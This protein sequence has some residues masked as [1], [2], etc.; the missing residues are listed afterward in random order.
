[1]DT[2]EMDTIE[3]GRTK[4]RVGRLVLG[5]MLMGTRTD[6]ATAGAILDRYADRGGTFLDT[7]NCYMWWHRR[8]SRGGESEEL[9]GRWLA[10]TGRRDEMFLATKGGGM[11]TDGGA[12]TADGSPDWARMRF[13]G[14]GARTLRDAVDASL[15][16]LRTDHIDLYYVHVDDRSTPLEETL[17]ELHAIVSAGKVRHL[18]WSNVATWRL[19]RIRQLCDRHGWTAPVAVQ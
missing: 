12:W 5:C 2:T 10:R 9:L 3:L 8:G 6:E 17:A 13:E 11:V 19:E 14:A 15:R 1:M 7:A 16:R 4:D 18:G